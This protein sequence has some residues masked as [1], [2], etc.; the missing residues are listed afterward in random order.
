[1]LSN[2][3]TSHTLAFS[4]LQL[5]RVF[6]FYYLTLSVVVF[7]KIQSV[8]FIIEQTMC[9]AGVQRVKNKT[10]VPRRPCRLV[11]RFCR[12]AQVA[13]SENT[14]EN[15]KWTFVPLPAAPGPCSVAFGSNGPLSIPAVV[16]VSPA[17][18]SRVEKRA[19]SSGS[20]YESRPV[21]RAS[22]WPRPAN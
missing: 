20:L 19:F 2:P 17:Y 21:K 10:F 7:L 6:S 18:K 8:R 4:F 14:A 16:C 15:E 5:L 3:V 13:R 22:L 9:M 12:A 1:M 11:P